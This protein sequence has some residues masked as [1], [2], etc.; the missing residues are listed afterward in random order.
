MFF[1]RYF[2]HTIAMLDSH[3]KVREGNAVKKNQTSNKYSFNLCGTPE[4]V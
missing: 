3:S 1:K 2:H 4:K